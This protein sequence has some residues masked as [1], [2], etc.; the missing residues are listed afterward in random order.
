MKIACIG[1]NYKQFSLTEIEPFY[2][3]KEGLDQLMSTIESSGVIH[4]CVP[5]LTC[6]RMEFYIATDAIDS[7]YEWIVSEI[8]K[9]KSQPV[10]AV[11]RVIQVSRDSAAINHLFNVVSGIESMVFGETEILSQ[12]KLA[13]A[14]ASERGLTGTWL[15][16]LFQSAVSCG[17]RVRAETQISTGACSVSSIA[18]DA[19]KSHHLDY[20]AKKILIIGLG[21]MGVRCLKKLHALGHPNITVCNRTI[22]RSESCQETFCVSILPFESLGT[23]LCD[24]DIV[25]SAISCK[26]PLITEKMLA[27]PACPSLMI[28]L[29]LPRNVQLN[30]LNQI[31]VISVEGLKSHANA[32]TKR[33]QGELA[34]ANFIIQDEQS[35]FY[36]WSEYKQ[37][38]AY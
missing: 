30:D 22:T 29:G 3:A 18:I 16:K 20:F 8:S 4:E 7:A 34:A 2:F 21:A 28:D 31:T 5:L 6:N 26:Y 1:T 15:N 10:S 23:A 19:I 24:Y 12:V 11:K 35:K 14:T 17:K 38:H 9:R 36:Q 13:Y 32:N 25:I 33:R 27:K 37:H